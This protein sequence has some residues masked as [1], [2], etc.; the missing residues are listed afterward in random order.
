MVKLLPT[1]LETRVQS[2]GRE[3]L[4]EKRTETHSSVVAPLPQKRG[5]KKNFLA[6]PIFIIYTK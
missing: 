1:M 4:L 2:L 6:N 5:S 3:D